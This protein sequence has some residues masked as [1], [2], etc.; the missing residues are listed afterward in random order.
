M[1][2]NYCLVLVTCGS[3]DEAGAIARRLVTDGLAAG[4]Q[5][6]PI[7]SVYT[8]K[9]DTVEDD[10]VLLICKTRSDLFDEIESVV[11]EMHSYDVPPILEIAIDGASALYLNWIADVTK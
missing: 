10:E 2:G 11:A 8:W 9:G 5:R 6:L 7:S 3:H 1:S 4:V